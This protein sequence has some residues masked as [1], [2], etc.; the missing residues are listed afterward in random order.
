M[1]HGQP[2]NGYT[3]QSQAAPPAATVAYRHAAQAMLALATDP[4][5]WIGTA[6]FLTTAVKYRRH[7]QPRWTTRPGRVRHP[8]GPAAGEHGFAH[9]APAR[10]PG[11]ATVAAGP[12]PVHPEE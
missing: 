11:L 8:A 1:T 3:L 7:S 4:E 9:N 10:E 2:K 5:G 6:P 12:A